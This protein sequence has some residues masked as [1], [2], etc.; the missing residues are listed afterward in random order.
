[1]TGNNL[2]AEERYIKIFSD[3]YAAIQVLNSSLLTSQLVKDTV[4]AL[5]LVGNKGDKLEISCIK[6]RV[7]HPGKERA[8]QRAREAGNLEQNTYKQKHNTLQF[9]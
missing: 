6:A 5:N 8:D 9:L 1:M 2:T 3:S 7:G 4:K